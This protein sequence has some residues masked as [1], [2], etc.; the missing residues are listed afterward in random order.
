MEK[1]T[2]EGKPIAVPP[3]DVDATRACI[4]SFICHSVVARNAHQRHSIPR[5]RREPCWIG[6]FPYTHPS[7]AYCDTARHMP[8]TTSHTAH[9]KR[10]IVT[11]GR[12][13]TGVRS[14]HVPNE[15]GTTNGATT[16]TSKGKTKHVT[17]GRKTQS[18]VRG[19]LRT[20]NGTTGLHG[21]RRITIRFPLVTSVVRI[22]GRRC[23]RFIVHRIGRIAGFIGY[24]N[25]GSPA[26]P[27]VAAR[28]ATRRLVATPTAHRLQLYI[29]RVP[30]TVPAYWGEGRPSRLV[31]GSIR[32][33]R[34]RIRRGLNGNHRVTAIHLNAHL[35]VRRRRSIIH[36]ARTRTRTHTG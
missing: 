34:L 20:I 33:A 36:C 27:I 15:T 32:R 9:C 13:V 24:K 30:C 8:H 22:S 26:S 23:R 29:V 28:C 3:L 17:H 10:F 7:T 31:R 19:K 14:S 21:S 6:F 4:V 25:T 18:Q 16:S 2:T 11:N 12:T 35:H 1:L 5:N